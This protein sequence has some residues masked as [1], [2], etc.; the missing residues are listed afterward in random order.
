[1]WGESGIGKS[2]FVRKLTQDWATIVTDNST[3]EHL[4]ED[5]KE[6]LGEIVI[7]VSILMR[8]IT[9]ETATLRK[10]LETQLDLTASQL[11]NLN[12]YLGE[13]S[14]YAVL[15]CDG[16]DEFN[17]VQFCEILEIIKGN[18]YKDIGCVVTCRPHSAQGLKYAVDCEIH[19]NGFNKDQ[20]KHY[21]ISYIEQINEDAS[22]K[23]SS[24]KLWNQI[25]ESPDLL[26][27]SKNP[28][29]LHLMC[30]TYTNSED[31]KL[32]S[33]ITSV[34]E[35]YIYFL[36]SDYHQKHIVDHPDEQHFK[37]KQIMKK[38]HDDL[39][40]MGELALQGL[41]SDHLS[42]LFS[43]DEVREKV[44]E[45]AFEL[46]FITNVPNSDLVVFHH[47]SIQEYLA[48]FYVKFADKEKGID[49]FL[50]FCTTAEH[51]MSSHVIL[52][53]ILSM[54][55]KLHRQVSKAIGNIIST[56]EPNTT[57]SSHE[58]TQFLLTM[59]KD[60]RKLK[61]PLPKEV[62]LDL[63]NPAYT[64]KS[65]FQSKSLVEL[66]CQQKPDGVQSIHLIAKSGKDLKSLQELSKA[67]AKDL[68]IDFVHHT[69]Y[70]DDLKPLMSPKLKTLN[71][72]HGKFTDKHISKLASLCHSN[73]TL[74][75]DECTT[76]ATGLLDLQEFSHEKAYQ[77]REYPKC[78][79][80][81][82]IL[83]GLCQE[84]EC[85]WNENVS[86]EIKDEIKNKNHLTIFNRIAQKMK[87]LS[88]LSLENCSIS[89]SESF[90]EGLA[91]CDKL[92]KLRMVKCKAE[93]SCTEEQ[94]VTSAEQS[95]IEEQSVASAEQSRIE[96]QS[97]ASLFSNEKFV[98]RLK[99]LE[100]IDC[101]FK[102]E[103]A[104]ESMCKLFHEG[105]ES[106]IEKLN[107]SEND[108][109][110]ALESC[111]QLLPFL[112]H[113]RE[114]KMDKANL[115]CNTY[116]K[117]FI[118]NLLYHCNELQVLDLSNNTLGSEN[119]SALSKGISTVT[120]L[121][122]LYLG[123][124]ELEKKSFNV[125]L[126]SSENYPWSKNIDLT[127]YKISSESI[128][129][130]AE[131]AP[132]PKR[133]T[134][135]EVPQVK[136][137][138]SGHENQ[139]ITP[140][141]SL[142]KNLKMIAE[143]LRV[144]D[145]SGTKL[146]LKDID[147]FTA[148]LKSLSKVQTIAMSK[149]YCGNTGKPVFKKFVETLISLQSL[150]KLCLDGNMFYPQ[151]IV[152]LSFLRTRNIEID[153]PDCTTEDGETLIKLLC[154]TK[155]DWMKLGKLDL[156]GCCVTKD[157]CEALLVLVPYFQNID[158]LYL[159][160]NVMTTDF[161]MNNFMEKFPK[162]EKLRHM[163][164]SDN[165]CG[166]KS[167]SSLQAILKGS[168]SLESLKMNRCN[169]PGGEEVVSLVD[170]ILSSC[171]SVVELSMTDNNVHCEA[172][173]V[174]TLI[175]RNNITK[176]DYPNCKSNLMGIFK[177]DS[178]PWEE[179][180]EIKEEKLTESEM[181]ALSRAAHCM[182]NLETIELPHL[183]QQA[184]PKLRKFLEKLPETVALKRV[185]ITGNIF[186]KEMVKIVAK[187]FHNSE[188]LEKYELPSKS[189]QNEAY[190][191]PECEH[192]EKM[193][194]S[195][196]QIM[197]SDRKQEGG[198]LDKNNHQLEMPVGNCSV[199]EAF[200][201]IVKQLSKCCKKVEV[202]EFA[203][204]DL[205]S[206]VS[207]DSDV[208]ALFDLC[209]ETPNLQKLGLSKC[210]F[211]SNKHVEK[212]IEN[213]HECCSNLEY[214]DFSKNCL[215]P[216][217]FVLLVLLD[218]R[219]KK[220]NESLIRIKYPKFIDGQNERI[221]RLCLEG[222][223][224]WTK[225][226]LELNFSE[227][228]LSEEDIEA[229]SLIVCEATE[230]GEFVVT[231]KIENTAKF[232][233][234]LHEIK[235]KTKQ[236]KVLNLS[237]NETN[238]ISSLLDILKASDQLT[239][240]QLANSKLKE[241]KSIVTV[242]LETSPH[243]TNFD[244]SGNTVDPE[245]MDIL[246]RITNWKNLKRLSLEDCGINDMNN[247]VLSLVNAC[248]KLTE[249]GLKKNK[250]SPIVLVQLT[251]LKHERN[252]Q[253]SYPECYPIDSECLVS[254]ITEQENKWCEQT[255]LSVADL[256]QDS[257]SAV[258]SVLPEMDSLHTLDIQNSI[259]KDRLTHDIECGLITAIPNQLNILNLSQNILDNHAKSLSQLISE[260]DLKCLILEGCFFNCSNTE[261]IVKHLSSK[262][263]SSLTTLSLKNCLAKPVTLVDLSILSSSKEMAVSYPRLETK[264]GLDL[265][266]LCESPVQVWEELN[267]LK[268][269][270][271]ISNDGLA[272]LG[273]IM[274][275][276]RGLKSINFSGSDMKD[277]GYL[278]KFIENVQTH[279]KSIETIDLSNNTLNAKTLKAVSQLV[280][281][282][283]KMAKIGLGHCDLQDSSNLTNF[284]ESLTGYCKDLTT[285]L[286]PE[287]QMNKISLQ[288]I[289]ELANKNPRLSELDLSN[290]N[291]STD[292]PM[293]ALLNPLK[294]RKNLK[295]DL[296]GNTCKPTTIVTLKEFEKSGATIQYP[297]HT[298]NTSKL[299][300]NLLS[301][302]VRQWQKREAISNANIPETFTEW[303]MHA[304]AMIIKHTSN[305]KVLELIN[306]QKSVGIGE[307]MKTLGET[308]IP[309]EH[310]N[311]SE[312]NL[313]TD[314]SVLL[315]NKSNSFKH[316]KLFSLR[317]C[318]IQDNKI[319]SDLISMLGK[320]C[321]DL[322]SLNMSGNCLGDI[323]IESLTDVLPCMQK[324]EEI[325]L[326]QCGIIDTSLLK[327]MLDKLYTC[328][329]SLKHLNL[330][331]NKMDLHAHYALTLFRKEKESGDFKLF[332]PCVPENGNKKLAL[333]CQEKWEKPWAIENKI[334]FK[335]EHFQDYEI[336]VLSQIFKH[337]SS[338][339]EFVLDGC[340]IVDTIRLGKLIESLVSNCT[341]INVLNLGGN[342]FDS[343]TL[344]R[345]SCKVM[346][347]KLSHLKELHLNDC[348]IDVSLFN[349]TETLINFLAKKAYNLEMINLKNNRMAPLTLLQ[350]TALKEKKEKMKEIIYPSVEE[351][352]D[353]KTFIQ[354]LKGCPTTLSELQTIKLGKKISV[355]GCAAV[356]VLPNYTPK[357]TS[358]ILSSCQFAESGTIGTF[359]NNLR[360]NPTVTHSERNQNLKVLK[361]DNISL[362]PDSQCALQKCM[363]VFSNIESLNFAHCNLDEDHLSSILENIGKQIKQLDLSH[364][365]INDTGLTNL[366]TRLGPNLEKL[367]LEN[368]EISNAK[369]TERLIHT[370]ARCINLRSV[371]LKDNDLPPQ[372][373]VAITH[374][375]KKTSC[376]VDYPL[377]RRNECNALHKLCTSD[378]SEID[379]VDLNGQLL[380]EDSLKAICEI[381]KF[382]V[383]IKTLDFGSCG[384]HNE[385][386]MHTIIENCSQI[387]QL[388]KCDLS[389]CTLS[390]ESINRFSNVLPHLPQL[391]FL[392]FSNCKL[393][394]KNISSLL[395]SIKIHCKNI[396]VL[397]LS[398]N[399]LDQDDLCGLT[400]CIT[401]LPMEHL[402]LSDCNI[403][404]NVEKLIQMLHEKP[405]R[406]QKLDLSGNKLFPSTIAALT[407]LMKDNPCLEVMYPE[408]SSEDDV[409]LVQLC[410][411]PPETWKAL[412]IISL[413]NKRLTQRGIDSLATIV[414]HSAQ[415][416]KFIIGQDISAQKVVL[417]LYD[418][419]FF[420]STYCQNI[421]TFDISGYN[422][423][424]IV[425]QVYKTIA[426]FSSLVELR[427]GNCN[428]NNID[429]LDKFIEETLD[430]VNTNTCRYNH[431]DF[432]GN[433]ASPCALVMLNEIKQKSTCDVTIRFPQC[434]TAD[435]IVF[436]QICKGEPKWSDVSEVS[437]T[438]ELTEK[439]LQAMIRVLPFLTNLKRVCLDTC[440]LNSDATCQVLKKLGEKLTTLNVSGN[441]LQ[442]KGAECLKNIS[443]SI[444]GIKTLCLSNCG[445]DDN[446][447]VKLVGLLNVCT[448]LEYLDISRNSFR[449]EGLA[450]LTI[451]L[452]N[453]KKLFHL[454]IAQCEIVKDDMNVLLQ[455]L[456]NVQTCPTLSK[457]DLQGNKAGLNQL[458]LLMSFAQTHP[459]LDIIYPEELEQDPEELNSENL[460]KI[461]RWDDQD[462]INIKSLKVTDEN[463]KWIIHILEHMSHLFHL[464][465]A[466]CELNDASA[467]GI[468]QTV[469]SHSAQIS[470]INFSGNNLSSVF[471]QC[472]SDCSDKMTQLTKVIL[473]SCGVSGETGA[474]FMQQINTHCSMLE[475]L[476]LSGNNIGHDVID[477]FPEFAS[478]HPN[479]KELHLANCG[480]SSCHAGH[481]DR[482]LRR[483]KLECK[484]LEKLDLSN[485]KCNISTIT[486]QAE[487]MNDN[488]NRTVAFPDCE[489]CDNENFLHLCKY[490]TPWMSNEEINMQNYQ[491]TSDSSKALKTVLKHSISI[492]YLNVNNCQLSENDFH[493]VINSVSSDKIE[494]LNVSHNTIGK[495]G[496]GTL[497]GKIKQYAHLHELHA[498]NLSLPDENCM[499][500][501]INAI[502][503]AKLKI[504]DLSYNKFTEKNWT[505]LLKALSNRAIHAVPVGSV[506]LID[507]P[508]DQEFQ[509]QNLENSKKVDDLDL[510]MTGNKADPLILLKLSDLQLHSIKYPMCNT[511]DDESLVSL[512]TASHE[513]LTCMKKVDL[514][515]KQ[516]S[517]KGSRATGYV[518][519][520][521]PNLECLL[522]SGIQFVSI[523]QTSVFSNMIAEIKECS[524]I[525]T[526][527]LSHN[528]L[529]ELCGDIL[530]NSFT[531]MKLVQKLNLEN[532]KMTERQS[533]KIV[534]AVL[535][536]CQELRMLNMSNNI[537]GKEGTYGF[538]ENIKASSVLE[539]LNISCCR[540]AGKHSLFKLLD[541][542]AC[543]SRLTELYLDH[544][545]VEISVIAHFK[546]IFEHGDIKYTQPDPL[547]KVSDTLRK[548]CTSNV[549]WANISEI[550]LNQEL[551]DED[552]YE[553]I[554]IILP[555]TQKLKH[556]TLSP[557][558]IQHN[559]TFGGVL[560][561][562]KDCCSDLE[563]LNLSQNIFD[564]DS[565]QTFCDLLPLHN[566]LR[567][568]QLAKCQIPDWK[569][570]LQSVP[571]GELQLLNLQEN[572][573]D[574]EMFT[575]ISE[576]YLQNKG[577]KIFFPYCKT[578][579]DKIL[580]DLCQSQW[581]EVEKID[582]S[583]KQINPEGIEALTK[584]V[585]QAENLKFF[586]ISGCAITDNVVMETLVATLIKRSKTLTHL[587]IS[588][589][590][591][592]LNG[593][594]KLVK[595]LQSGTDD[596]KIQYLSTGHCGLTGD[597]FLQDIILGL[598]KYQETLKSLNMSGTKFD[599]N[600]GDL[601]NQF[602]TSNCTLSDLLLNKSE[603]SN[604]TMLKLIETIGHT[605]IEVLD[606]NESEMSS[607]I[608][609]EL[610][611]LKINCPELKLCYPNCS[612]TG[613]NKFIDLCQGTPRWSEVTS[614]C[615]SNSN[616][617]V[618]CLKVLAKITRK[619]P[620]TKL[621]D[622]TSIN[623]KMAT[624]SLVC[625]ILSGL[626][627]LK[628][629]LLKQC[630]ISEEEMWKVITDY[631][632]EAK[633]LENIN[634]ESNTAFPTTVFALSNIKTSR[635]KLD[636]I[637]PDCPSDSWYLVDLCKTFKT[638]S[639][640]KLPDEEISENGIQAMLEVTSA[641]E[642]LTTF[643]ISSCPRNNLACTKELLTALSQHRLLRE[644]NLSGRTI[645]SSDIEMLS[646]YVKSLEH[647]KELKLAFCDITEDEN[648]K[649]ILEAINNGLSELKILDISGSCV[650]YTSTLVL[651]TPK[652]LN[653]QTLLLRKCNLPKDKNTLK[654]VSMLRESKVEYIDLSDNIANIDIILALKLVCSK[655]N[656]AVEFPEMDDECKNIL[657]ITGLTDE[658]PFEF[659]SEHSQIV[660]ILTNSIS[661]THEE[662]FKISDTKLSCQSLIDALETPLECMKNL[663]TFE[664]SSCT[665]SEDINL[666]KIFRVGFSSPTLAI[667]NLSGTN[668]GNSGI[669]DLCNSLTEVKNLTDL[670]LS[671]CDIS[672]AKV[673]STLFK[674]LRDS[675]HLIENLN[676]SYNKIE[677]DI[678]Q[679]DLFP[680][681]QE[682]QS[683]L[684]TF[685]ISNCH[686]NMHSCAYDFIKNLKK[687]CAEIE[688]IQMDSNILPVDA[689]VLL[690]TLGLPIYGIFNRH[691][692]MHL[693]VSD[694]I[695]NWNEHIAEMKAFKVDV[696][697]PSVDQ[698]VFFEKLGLNFDRKL[699]VEP[700]PLINDV[701]SEKV[702]QLVECSPDQWPNLEE[703]TDLNFFHQSEVNAIAE[704][705]NLTSKL[706]H[707]Y[708]ASKEEG[709]K[710]REFLTCLEKSG[711]SIQKLNLSRLCREDNKT[712]NALLGQTKN[713][714]ELHLVNCV[715]QDKL[716][717][718]TIGTKCNLL[719]DLN[720]SENKICP[721]GIQ[722]LQEMT[723]NSKDLQ[724]LRLRNCGIDNS[725]SVTELIVSLFE[726]CSKLELID[727]SQNSIHINVHILL[728]K[729][730]RA[731][732]LNPH[733]IYPDCDNIP[734]QIVDLSHQKPNSWE[735]WKNITIHNQTINR[736]GMEALSDIIEN[737]PNLRCFNISGC[738]IPDEQITSVLSVMAKQCPHLTELDLSKVHLKASS[739]EAI[740]ES[741]TK[742]KD[743]TRICI[744]GCQLQKQPEIL[745]FME[746]I[747]KHCQSLEWLDM[748]N[749]DVQTGVI[750]LLTW[751][752]IKKRTKFPE[753]PS[754]SNTQ[755]LP[756]LKGEPAPW[757]QIQT[758][759]LSSLSSL[760]A[761]D[762]YALNIML[763]CASELTKLK[764]G[765]KNLTTDQLDRLI[766]DSFSDKVPKL[767]E[768]NLSN[769]NIEHIQDD[770]MLNIIAGHKN[771]SHLYLDGCKLNQETLENCLEP[772]LNVSRNLEALGLSCNQVGKSVLKLS[773]LPE[774]LLE[775]HLSHSSIK[776]NIG[777]QQLTDHLSQTCHSL[778]LLDLSGN[779]VTPV[780][781]VH[782]GKVRNNIQSLEIKYPDMPDKSNQLVA[783]LCR[784]FSSHTTE[785]DLSCQAISTV[786]AEAISLIIPKIKRVKVCN[787]SNMQV[788]NTEYLPQIVFEAFGK[789]E[790]PNL[791][792]L[793][794]SNNKI[795]S[796]SLKKA[797]EI[798]PNLKNLNELNLKN[799][800]I[801]D[802]RLMSEFLEA[803]SKHCSRLHVLD[804]TSNHLNRAA[805]S[806]ITSVSQK[807]P[808]L[809]QL[810]L[811]QCNI[812]DTNG[813]QELIKLNLE[814]HTGLKV[815]DLAENQLDL[816][817]FVGMTELKYLR[818]IKI[819][820]PR[821]TTSNPN[822]V[823]ISK[824]RFSEIKKVCLANTEMTPDEQSALCQLISKTQSLEELDISHCSMQECILTS[825]TEALS[826]SSGSLRVLNMS[827][828]VLNK[829]GEVKFLQLL[830]KLVYIKTLYLPLCN[831][832]ISQIIE[833]LG[834]PN[835]CQQLRYL[836]V[837]DILMS[838]VVL[839]KLVSWAHGNNIKVQHSEKSASKCQPIVDLINQGPDYWKIC[840]KINWTKLV[841]D[842][843]D[844][845]ALDQLFVQ[846]PKLQQ[847][848]MQGCQFANQ[849]Q[850]IDWLKK[851]CEHSSEIQEITFSD[852]NIGPDVFV[853]VTD[854]TPG[855][856]V[857]ECQIKNGNCFKSLENIF[858]NIKKLD[859]SSNNIG[860]AGCQSLLSLFRSSGTEAQ[861]KELNI[862][863]CNITDNDIMQDLIRCLEDTDIHT[864]NMEDNELDVKTTCFLKQYN[865]KCMEIIYPTVAKCSKEIKY[866]TLSDWETQDKIDLG[867][868]SITS[869]E[870]DAL[871]LILENSP[872]K[873]HI[874]LDRTKFSADNDINCVL[875]AVCDEPGELSTLILT[876]QCH[877]NTSIVSEIIQKA[878]KLAILLLDQC[879]LSENKTEIIV[880]SLKTKRCAMQELNLAGNNAKPISMIRLHKLKK[881]NLIDR[882]AVPNIVSDTAILKDLSLGQNWKYISVP[883]HTTVTMELFEFLTEIVECEPTQM[884][885]ITETDVSEGVTWRSLI[886]KLLSNSTSLSD[887][888][889]TKC[890]IQDEGLKIITDK[891]SQ[892]KQLKNVSLVQ[893]SV[894]QPSM[895]EFISCLS[896]NN[897]LIEHLDI[898]KNKLSEEL[899]LGLC[900]MFDSCSS[901]NSLSLAKC[902]YGDAICWRKFLAKIDKCKT[903]S[904]KE[905]DIRSN[906]LSPCMLLEI[907]RLESE[908]INVKHDENISECHKDLVKLCKMK[909]DKLAHIKV[910]ELSNSQG[911][912][913]DGI[914]ALETI[915]HQTKELQTFIWTKYKTE[916][917]L[918]FD[919]AIRALNNASGLKKLN[920]S[921]NLLDD[922]SI[923]ALVSLQFENLNIVN[924]SKCR[925]T[926]SN[927][928]KLLNHIT[929][930]SQHLQELNLS[931][932]SFENTRTTF[933]FDAVKQLPELTKLNLNSS[934][935]TKIDSIDSNKEDFPKLEELDLA[936]NT[937][938]FCASIVNLAL[939]DKSHPKLSIKFPVCHQQITPDIDKVLR[940][941]SKPFSEIKE[942]HIK[943]SM[944]TD[945][946]D[947]LSKIITLVPELCSFSVEKV[948]HD[949][950]EKI[951]HSAKEKK[952]NFR[953][954]DLSG[955]DLN[956]DQSTISSI[957]SQ[958]T[959]LRS[960]KLSRC[961]L[962]DPVSLLKTVASECK[963]ITSI[964]LTEN[965]F[966]V[967]DDS[968]DDFL[969]QREM[970]Q[971]LDIL[972]LANCSVH[973]YKRSESLIKYL[974]SI[975]HLKTLNLKNSQVSPNMFIMLCKSDHILNLDPP[976]CV[977]D[978]LKI[979]KH[980]ITDSKMQGKQYLKPLMDACKL[981]CITQMDLSNNT[982][983]SEGLSI[984]VSTLKDIPNLQTLTLQNCVIEAG[985]TFTNLMDHLSTHSE[986]LKNL[987]LAHNEI[988]KSDS[989]AL[990]RF[991]RKLLNLNLQDTKMTINNLKSLIHNI[992]Q[993]QKNIKQLNL[994]GNKCDLLSLVQLSR[995][996]R[997]RKMEVMFPEC[998]E[999]DNTHLIELC[1000]GQIP[1001][1002]MVKYDNLS[1003]TKIE[1004]IAALL[1005]D[1006]T[1007]LRNQ[1008]AA[1009]E[1010]EIISLTGTQLSIDPILEALANIPE[1011]FNGL[1012]LSKSRFSIEKVFKVV[1013]A[1014]KNIQILN[1015][1016]DCGLSNEKMVKLLTA[1017]K[1018]CETLLMLDLS[1019]NIVGDEGFELLCD[1020]N[1021]L[1022][1023]LKQLHLANSGIS[1024]GYGNIISKL[1025]NHNDEMNIL[1026][1027]SGNSASLI[1028]LVD[1029]NQLDKERGCEVGLILPQCDYP[1030]SKIRNI[1031]ESLET[1032]AEMTEIKL[1033]G[1034]LHR[1035]TEALQALVR[1036]VSNSPKLSH[1037]HLCDIFMSPNPEIDH[1038]LAKVLTATFK[1039]CKSIT[1040]ID[1041]SK[1042]H[1043]SKCVL[1044]S[1045]V[1046][1047]LIN[1048]INLE[1049]LRLAE[1050][1051]IRNETTDT[1052]LEL[1053][1054]A[1055]K[1056]NCHIFR[1057][1058]DLKGN[1059]ISPEVYLSLK[1060]Y[1061][1062][1063]EIN[1064][1065][1066][1067]KTILKTSNKKVGALFKKTS[1068][1069]LREETSIDLSHELLTPDETKGL[1070][1071]LLKNTTLKVTK[1072]KLNGCQIPQSFTNQILEVTSIYHKLER[1073]DF[1074]QN[1075][1076][1077][1078]ETMTRL[1079]QCLPEWHALKKLRLGE[1080]TIDKEEDID[1081]LSKALSDIEIDTLDLT[1082]VLFN[1083]E[1084]NLYEIKKKFPKINHIWFLEEHKKK[1085]KGKGKW[1086]TVTSAA[1087][1088]AF[1089]YFTGRSDS[1090]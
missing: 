595:V 816:E 125:Q 506:D 936:S 426:K 446:S 903:K 654:F 738:D 31:V 438:K 778:K 410:R 352:V 694:F 958:S 787:L 304:F 500:D 481:I 888:L 547:P 1055:L 934:G 346:E 416:E 516:V 132:L 450:A 897:P 768:L 380:L 765:N 688:L 857:L 618:P 713:I 260:A 862:S 230:L 632:N 130:A 256:S 124:C 956:K 538:A 828:N 913:Q 335:N 606:L 383:N 1041:L 851:V 300:K 918:A 54:S 121:E 292:S 365:K 554:K 644:L 739:I 391:Q 394:S 67:K 360:A 932:N 1056:K 439:G 1009:A 710:Y 960:L 488:N 135:S 127:L 533:A 170:E 405:H 321:P 973:N 347:E 128:M 833:S 904:F 576:L 981:E 696:N 406:L 747:Q 473:Q 245:T 966:V 307:I 59:L 991:K 1043:V 709:L 436:C 310:I 204:N 940:D 586:S 295:L 306:C 1008:D 1045:I 136:T 736:D 400:D 186:E 581:N 311:L 852:N 1082:S 724:K 259:G 858:K 585:S 912:T 45:R 743:I 840:P 392:N 1017:I 930:S 590:L 1071:F 922:N 737:L 43:A 999:S 670:L 593:A 453:M 561:S 602:L 605:K 386:V 46:G 615:L 163:D 979:D 583:G 249:I 523:T 634:L 414:K 291:L 461:C 893:C 22:S 898:S 794:L 35:E 193:D 697:K 811:A 24:D 808:L 63:R 746:C 154:Q 218:Q 659:S 233:D 152:M 1040:M 588:S 718:E 174:L 848:Y 486:L 205:N 97:V 50:E 1003:S 248:P 119:A 26:Q 742:T 556:L 490:E 1049:V 1007:E 1022:P 236:L 225:P 1035:P 88:L 126:T 522:I 994:S 398:N 211:H 203:G 775:L 459:Q 478:C 274:K 464:N 604:K 614:I 818:N 887:V 168:P 48:A 809:R 297:N 943:D 978:T 363:K 286:L 460:T 793:N 620:E 530:V 1001:Q 988:G 1031:C 766:P 72:F 774:S 817:T 964:D 876:G 721:S 149:C 1026:N 885:I 493:E 684:K 822:L 923:D 814:S 188:M 975:T 869:V 1036:V 334:D 60:N 458:V 476:D 687:H 455:T 268:L 40:K 1088:S 917:S 19:L 14:K 777:L 244:I 412:K 378:W 853:K 175:K 1083:P 396:Q 202:L 636:I 650:G 367:S 532:C 707:I 801:K 673:F 763:S 867:K 445:L 372:T 272:A 369:L 94:S 463:K 238:D 1068:A 207:D 13:H 719:T 933:F 253:V 413:R 376:H 552:A 332:Y 653:I 242:V 153:D 456:Q 303:E 162:N 240:L 823:R 537:L 462:S 379:T 208:D 285:L 1064:V 759:D 992:F 424:E 206:L 91:D 434:G 58:R 487:I 322:T 630:S 735:E 15:I 200:G 789:N 217:S 544:N 674:R 330:S 1057:N 373:F 142:F 89:N 323:G 491:L 827:G 229:L 704:I 947:A 237:N 799:C 856:K 740:T 269:D 954:L 215:G 805:L 660:K 941:K 624:P 344:E 877:V 1059:T 643:D 861:M 290:C 648:L 407:T 638:K 663:H 658:R 432:S 36:L 907:S 1039:H 339:G 157:G 429:S 608:L 731:S 123:H 562:L 909:P 17:V 161:A 492:K 950:L 800:N 484:H 509:D 354:M 279:H 646:G 797:A 669:E 401:C 1011:Y 1023:V 51:L 408:S 336:D 1065:N 247:Q 101:E 529:G 106:S 548:L 745:K 55:S 716:I 575:S 148:A 21:V 265:I 996:V 34:F 691:V 210:N 1063:T 169:L 444:S 1089:T 499:A 96:E 771:L 639:E 574:L 298:E 1018:T 600:N 993:H 815:L 708:I 87:K 984:L 559:E 963:S 870:T 213:L 12:R 976:L 773:H 587:D 667:I 288:Q 362:P 150:Q 720:L 53:F 501:I 652:M 2:I 1075:E 234:V 364:N 681:K 402:Y 949:K 785:V 798:V 1054:K 159:P 425:E 428:M 469:S 568:L 1044:K 821:C 558:D 1073:L 908:G 141:Q 662:N 74:S 539:S 28:S 637:Y 711:K 316:V 753:Y 480:I 755:L 1062:E 860:N 847:L 597:S 1004:A 761:E 219:N 938:E 129:T 902:E 520:R 1027:L 246:S 512:W 942:V 189:F 102:V 1012:V 325:E 826:E 220:K 267:C 879:N 865:K 454:S 151:S 1002:R 78:H 880:N 518:L 651:S 358:I 388:E 924:L 734:D 374:M 564:S 1010:P 1061:A 262:K 730:K 628:T 1015:L 557:D 511:D 560:C 725:K 680:D 874:S 71:F 665:C 427:L 79:E 324:L 145:I 591:L 312:N 299:I 741:L 370:L 390:E 582:L 471:T 107:L 717:L 239:S 927:I 165:E 227:G 955:N 919:E 467:C 700:L 846:L 294:L 318:N 1081:P 944:S 863:N 837:G 147:T 807:N 468:I 437:L 472:L 195:N 611:Q 314:A 649:S 683:K 387:H 411:G 395:N 946:I 682:F 308:S 443:N 790:K 601:L 333:F 803:I 769:N 931:Q 935:I 835:I 185:T 699:I 326:E 183:D 864:L 6:R 995:L 393:N 802:A 796:D 64:E 338:L 241:T 703:L 70:I 133:L 952:C 712:L 760:T 567:E 4:T 599:D 791:Q 732:K 111:K 957:L 320:H 182:N 409:E 580:V 884:L 676:L 661:W 900:A 93:K 616:L 534:E 762:I 621:L 283:P 563:C 103:T 177:A 348:N 231:C 550:I 531:E 118:Q 752:K 972:Q 474:F 254:L 251:K 526:L 782:L 350:L 939:L 842:D 702:K 656:I 171:H 1051:N 714:T 422:C 675:C 258:A 989:I 104:L 1033:D 329:L 722:A 184:Y 224:K 222:L 415:L 969:W 68:K 664:I 1047:S 1078:S 961:C 375:K 622:L 497:A 1046:D 1060:M 342:R 545:Q 727:L 679:I 9:R 209:K 838:S 430:K 47:K 845:E 1048:A 751:L 570:F 953:E 985:K 194:M 1025:K 495:D 122:E 1084:I 479:L 98:R 566:N 275:Y 199:N 337:T 143:K 315:Q 968:I 549:I 319:T 76:N 113:L 701:K 504:L 226:N 66:F 57:V 42:L 926:D 536:N 69:P 477:C 596:P 982:L 38:Y 728:T 108:M 448:E 95:R 164:L 83:T 894:T 114:F 282:N 173:V 1042:T 179:L 351:S 435:C 977:T 831:Y 115:K 457:L 706:K 642:K 986:N 1087:T 56:M 368:C 855:M 178:L 52:N 353:D 109:T 657:N 214:V 1016:H 783:E 886:E 693:D 810:T 466:N 776:P 609:M 598:I 144:L 525:M 920:I 666:G 788:E 80:L 100:L 795:H 850:N 99:E 889:I 589:N 381:I 296:T 929:K 7:L 678:H 417:N 139:S 770:S 1058:L 906:V 915:L 81:G 726:N 542:L 3:P 92:T 289:V 331:E 756:L 29:I 355:S 507:Q 167:V 62:F 418:L 77:I 496:A 754:C 672:S 970:F 1072:I 449:N 255:N 555:R 829:E 1053:V 540:L 890:N 521:M 475:M 757:N 116:T 86:V 196:D 980:L 668:I 397:N 748:S 1069:Q 987:D 197:P 343:D 228:I 715:K 780:T 385:N 494:H 271:F 764:L 573:C 1019:G 812:T 250:L 1:M 983:G 90:A 571:K 626:E 23:I 695:K 901:L 612:D 895:K 623:L 257:I 327:A 655:Q 483:I 910:I 640:I 1074:R 859:L 882:L 806:A 85:P 625:E 198:I 541:H 519:G 825:L 359:L 356:A 749:N 187:H 223:K 868:I 729:K 524:K 792:I 1076:F 1052:F 1013:G 834:D 44:G 916:E 635:I 470:S 235:L 317:K 854:S 832:Q 440:K 18:K 419:L 839:L 631:V 8:N 403:S 5:G 881:Q 535:L 433:L 690:K 216:R 313:S 420:V 945:M 105:N 830:R 527:D 990:D 49:V 371:N 276:I 73:V 221:N 27:L 905:L 1086:S 744:P 1034:E 820:Y 284:L 592:D 1085:K 594:S 302:N 772:F 819:T 928:E 824:G 280:S 866:L 498:S 967:S 528:I 925:L 61:F 140:V 252:C 421:H 1000:K 689:I 423:S 138:I 883:E 1028:D 20:A 553:A 176:I 677:E 962:S 212:L 849:D 1037:L 447:M 137:E 485:N 366:A 11:E 287:C 891:L 191:L 349:E 16:L 1077:S 514:T 1067:D 293:D 131:L 232:S 155:D 1005:S 997:N 39:Y 872:K 309:L 134:I 698:I 1079:I 270:C 647:L 921:C 841:I 836:D 513:N 37:K 41:K 871:K 201:D 578:E 30:V 146:S 1080:Y 515:G 1021:F 551:L 619:C 786:E 181:S 243:M 948:S 1020:T 33:T 844:K 451:S 382:T 804:L 750:A 629:L 546:S 959:H 603:V 384:I 633:Y 610:T 584:V 120:E 345:L 1014:N 914:S 505:R 965:T 1050:C 1030:S 340:N 503:F 813:V 705:T 341:K 784:T 1032:W 579:N 971:K 399:K 508:G 607:E 75:F 158:T 10:I 277:A 911:M 117:Q 263:C 156:Y 441:N 25:D 110:K 723:K 1024:Q 328:C 190:A 1006:W 264:D 502:P 875:Q 261:H 645:L 1029:L 781:L 278:T 577:I 641:M 1066:Y 84:S 896:Q 281:T 357:V 82:P 1070:L 627:N 685:N 180:V 301:E 1038:C 166:E 431:L 692:T 465:V 266:K 974:C 613:H 489:N 951:L 517:E 32:G 377:W 452:K 758:L 779:E 899:L 767:K 569:L 172:V 160:N 617:S 543:L 112:R 404:E 442:N 1090:N 305:L 565:F 482:F 892:M 192:L 998:D 361:F 510:N 873:Q 843:H 671:Q 937:V 572:E 733:I 65:V 878:Y 389:G 273:G 686:M